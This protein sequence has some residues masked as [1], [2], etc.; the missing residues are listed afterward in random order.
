MQTAIPKLPL[1]KTFNNCR[2]YDLT[3]PIPATKHKVSVTV[4]GDYELHGAQKLVL[5]NPKMQFTKTENS[6]LYGSEIQAIAWSTDDFV[7]ADRAA[8][9]SH[10][11]NRVENMYMP[12]DNDGA[13][14]LLDASFNAARL[15]GF[16]YEYV[17]KFRAM[18]EFMESQ[19]EKPIFRPIGQNTKVVDEHT[20]LAEL[21]L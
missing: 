10:S 7:V 6:Y 4:N 11:Y 9:V 2:Y 8:K 3:P 5:P 21:M 15:N 19:Y 17:A 20:K 18:L 16:S 1:L 14:Y 12:G 13:S